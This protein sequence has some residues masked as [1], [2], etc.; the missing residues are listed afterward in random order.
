MRRWKIYELNCEKSSQTVDSRSVEMVP[1]SEALVSCPSV[2]I[3]VDGVHAPIVVG[4]PVAT[5]SFAM[6]D[7][8]LAEVM[9]MSHKN[10]NIGCTH[11]AQM[12][13]FVAHGG[14]YSAVAAVLNQSVK[15]SG[16]DVEMATVPSPIAVAA[17]GADAKLKDPG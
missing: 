11:L 17:Y 15:S 10:G 12:A 16:S 13:P 7:T 2:M 1:T 9:Y 3:P 4:V 8:P 6:W 5:G 14:V